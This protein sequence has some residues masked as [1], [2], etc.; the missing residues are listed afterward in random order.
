MTKAQ[1]F[2]PWEN[3]V[4]TFLETGTLEELLEHFDITPFEAFTVLLGNGLIDER[5]LEELSGG[6]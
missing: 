6:R 2:E 5:T 3:F 4:D 1:D